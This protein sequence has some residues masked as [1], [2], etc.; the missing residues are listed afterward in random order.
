MFQE[1]EI[2]AVSGIFW[3][4]PSIFLLSIIGVEDRPVD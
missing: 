4:T 1:M 2:L 3:L